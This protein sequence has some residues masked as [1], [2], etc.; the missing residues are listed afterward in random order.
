MA[1]VLQPIACP[2]PLRGIIHT[3]HKLPACVQIFAVLGLNVVAAAV[4]DACDARGGGI[5]A[6]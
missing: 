1:P 5:L 4:C 2:S 6:G 3:V